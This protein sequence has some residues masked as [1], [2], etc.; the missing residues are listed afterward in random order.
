[1]TGRYCECAAQVHSGRPGPCVYCV[2]RRRRLHEHALLAVLLAFGLF[3]AAGTDLRALSCHV[4]I[5]DM[6]MDAS[7]RLLLE[8]RKRLAAQFHVNHTTIQFER[9]GLP[10]NRPV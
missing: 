7:E 2:V 4:R 9:A 8:I 10:S 1:M 3:A 6:H 5:P